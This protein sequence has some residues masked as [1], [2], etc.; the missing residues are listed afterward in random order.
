MNVGMILDKTFPPDPRV[1]N[2]ALSLIKHGHQVY[3]YCFN[4][5]HDQ[6]EIEMI[7]GIHV[8]RQR[9]PKIVYRLSALAYTI[10]LYHWY[11]KRSILVFAKK[12]DIQVIHIHDMQVARSIFSLRKKL[13]LPTI[14][15]LHEN[16]PEIMKY[17]THVRTFPG[18]LLIFPSIW[19]RFE[20]KYIKEADRVIVVTKES[21]EYYQE[22]LPVTS[23]KFCIVPNTVRKEFYNDFELDEVLINKYKDRFTILYLGE[24]GIRR[25]I[26]TAIESIQYLVEKIP[27]IKLVL[28]G[29]SRTDSV[30]K[31]M[32]AKYGLYDYVDLMGW[33]DFALF[34]S[35]VMA[36]KIGISPLH[37]N[38]HHETTFANKLFQY[39]AFGKPVV[40]SNCKAQMNIVKAYQCG[41]VFKDRDAK[42]LANQI[43]KLYLDTDL[44]EHLSNNAMKAIEEHLNWDKQAESLI[45]MYDTIITNRNE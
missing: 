39:L 44:Y 42:D 9:L 10:P 41:L 25:G 34:P 1:E 5:I 33:Q 43:L 26:P 36:S 40:V 4:F 38:L 28:V 23:D 31:D 27:N 13:N 35:Y 6:P 21:R 12:N 45:E 16:R 15:D 37:R 29:S 32:V 22:K 2:E 18:N 24:T 11:L 7:K 3:L 17:Y 20:F 8:F 14:L 19:K 30:L